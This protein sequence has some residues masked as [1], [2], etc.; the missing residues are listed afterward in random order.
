MKKRKRWVIVGIF[1]IVVAAVAVA[2]VL[3]FGRDKASSVHYLTA[4]VDHG[5]DL[6]D[7]PGRLHAE[8][9]ERH[10]L[11]RARRWGAAPTRPPVRPAPRARRR[12]LPPRR[13]SSSG[14]SVASAGNQATVGGQARHAAATTYVGP[15]DRQVRRRQPTCRGRAMPP[16]VPRPL[17]RRPR[18]P[19]RLHPVPR[20]TPTPTPTRTACPH[21]HAVAVRRFPALGWLGRRDRRLRR[22]LDLHRRSTTS[23]SSSSS[24]SGVVTRLS[25]PAGAKP[26]TLRRVLFVSGKPVFAF[27]SPTPLW[28]N[29]STSL[30]SGSQRANVAVLQ[31][32]LKAQ[33]YY[34]K[35]I[36][37]RFTSATKKAYKRWQKANGMSA[38]GILDV[39]RFVWMPTGS[40]LTAWTREPWQPRQFGYRPGVGRLAQQAH[41]GGAHQPGRHRR[42]EGGT[43]GAR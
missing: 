16:A 6:A 2:G 1:V 33:G 37:G 17:R 3:W 35:A 39:S 11:R 10:D 40:V 28:K 36:N 19:R 13:A 31:R 30:S 20:P 5:D 7:R 27:V 38:T 43:E 42:P 22:R 8:L 21:A 26:A 15:D 34:K 14:L 23:S 12:R 25:L 29:L 41:R 32:A 9:R 24:L 4:K 18:R